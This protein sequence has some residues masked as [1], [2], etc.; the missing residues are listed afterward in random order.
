M[1][2]L[3][4]IL[5][6]VGFVCFVIAALGVTSPVKYVPA[7][8]PAGLAMWIFPLMWETMKQAF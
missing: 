2:E 8:V 6:L 7:L 1:I 3:Y 5:Y 4:A